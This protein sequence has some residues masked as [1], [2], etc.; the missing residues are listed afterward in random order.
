M[1]HDRYIIRPNP[2]GRSS[3]ID[4]FTDE[5]A[6]IGRLHLINL[7]PDEAADMVKILNDLDSLE[8]RVRSFAGL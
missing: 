5:P 7:H 3:I 8:R 6:T 2:V 4:I 1:R